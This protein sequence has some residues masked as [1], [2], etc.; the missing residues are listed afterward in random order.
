MMNP[1]GVFI[2]IEDTRT[3]LY[4]ITKIIFLLLS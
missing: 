3:K 1:D 2:S 4:I